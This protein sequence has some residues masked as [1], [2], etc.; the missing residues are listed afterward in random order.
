ME[1]NN[2]LRITIGDFTAVYNSGAYLGVR[3]C[4]RLD[5]KIDGDI[6]KSATEKTAKRYPYFCVRFAQNER[7]YYLEDNPLPVMTINKA[8]STGLLTE[9]VNYHAWAVCYIDDFIYF[10]V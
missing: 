7:E 6:L 8:T 9:A 10:D 2:K 4:V 1:N 5:D 3:L